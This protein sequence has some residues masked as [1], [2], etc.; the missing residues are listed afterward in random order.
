MLDTTGQNVLWE[1]SGWREYGRIFDLVRFLYY[2][3]TR[4][5]V[6]VATHPNM[7]VIRSASKVKIAREA[8]VIQRIFDLF[9]LSP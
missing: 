5:S 3:L 6:R 2:N 8:R 9:A 4:M 1:L 7:V